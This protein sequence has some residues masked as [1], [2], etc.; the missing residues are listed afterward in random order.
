MLDASKVERI[1]EA[2]KA[3]LPCHR[4]GTDQFSILGEYVNFQL[5]EEQAGIKIVGKAV[6]P[7]V[8]V[9]CNNCG[10]VTFH[11]TGILGISEDN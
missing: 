9:G 3:T 4:C 2:K 6:L 10:A 5:M 1:F 7:T 8:L 11:A